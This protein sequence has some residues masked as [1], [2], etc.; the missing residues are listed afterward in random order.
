MALITGSVTVKAETLEEWGELLDTI[1]AGLP[2][3]ITI[4]AQRDDLLELD[5]TFTGA[6]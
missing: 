6:S 4:N 2:A 5:V 1:A 3:T